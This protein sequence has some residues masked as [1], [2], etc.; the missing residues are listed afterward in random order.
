MAIPLLYT[1]VQVHYR[2]KICQFGFGLANRVLADV[3]M[4]TQWKLSLLA[5]M[6]LTRED[7]NHLKYIKFTTYLHLTKNDLGSV[8]KETTLLRAK[9]SG[10]YNQSYMSYFPNTL[11]SG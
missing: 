6:K 9:T 11:H 7:L 4:V 10:T 1:A 2:V 5:V 3:P 8:Q